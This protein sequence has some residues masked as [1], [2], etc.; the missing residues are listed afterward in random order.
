MKSRE[1]FTDLARLAR[2]IAEARV[3]TIGFEKDGQVHFT[4]AP[5]LTGE[6]VSVASELV[7]RMLQAGTRLEIPDL[8]K[9]EQLTVPE[10][11]EGVPP[12]QFFYGATVREIAGEARWFLAVLDRAPRRLKPEQRGGL[13][14]IGYQIF[15][16]V[17]Q[18][19]SAASLAQ[20]TAELQRA[21]AARREHEAFYQTLVESLPQNI[22][23]KDLDGRFTFANRRFC[24]MLGHPLEE[25][26]GK[27]DSDF[28]PPE[29]AHKYREDDRDVIQR[30][31]PL[32]TTEVNATPDGEKHWVH[33]IKT[34]ILDADGEPVGIQG[35]FWDV[36]K[37]KRAEELLAH[38]R[39]LLRALLDN[40]PDAIYFKDT[41]CRIT[42][43]SKALASKV[44]L[45]DAEGLVGKSDRDLF[46][47]EHAEQS[48]RD[49]LEIIRTGVPKLGY[50]EKETW[51]DGRITWALT[52][53]L[54]LRDR[55]GALIG[56]FGISKDITE[57]KLAQD[58]LERA[59]AN[60]RS[61]VENAI[62]GIFQTTPEGRYLSANPAL[63]RIYGFA[64][65]AELIQQR[66][67]IEHQVYVD[68]D[69]RNEFMRRMQ[70]FGQVDQFESQVYRADGNIFWISENARAVRDAEGTLAYYEGTV[71]DITARKRAEDELNRAYAELKCARD[72]ALES[73]ATKARFLAN[74]SH[75]LR[76]PMNAII[77]FSGLL[78]DTPMTAEQR[79]YAET[80][81]SSARA[82]L[83]LLNDILDFSKIDSGRLVF[84][85]LEFDPRRLIEDTAELMAELAFNKGLQFT[86]WL[87]HALPRQLHGDPGRV[88]QVVTNL[89]ANAIKF[90]EQ[91][92]VQ[93]RVTVE[94][95]N[96]T[97]TRLRFEV[98]DTGVGIPQNAQG[99]IFEAFT[100]AD[101]STTRRFGGSGLG[102]SISRIL[103]Q[104]MAGRIGFQSREGE[105][106]TFWFT[107]ELGSVRSGIGPIVAEDIAQGLRVLIV[108]AHAPTREMV[109]HE[110]EPF[111]C[112]CQFAE[113]AEETLQLLSMAERDSRRIDLALIDL[114]LPDSDGLGLSHEIGQR[115]RRGPIHITL[116]APLGQ[117]FEADA[118]R[119]AGISGQLVKPLRQARL[120]DCLR[121][122][123]SGEGPDWEESRQTGGVAPTRRATSFRIL[124]A[125]D[126]VVNQKV[127]LA[128]LKRLGYSAEIAVNGRRALE[129]LRS[130][131]FE[132][133]LLDC[134]MP[135]W[136]GYETARELRRLEAHGELGSRRPHYIIALTAHAMPGDREKCVA[137]G[138][139]DFLTKPLEIE[140][141]RV[142]LERAALALGYEPSIPSITSNGAAKPSELTPASA[143]LDSKFLNSLRALQSTDAPDEAGEFIDLYLK[144]LPQ[145]LELIRRAIVDRDAAAG[146]AATHALKGSSGNLG[147]KRL[148]GL[149]A[150]LEQALRA[151]DW[152]QA[153]RLL[154]A[155]EVEAGT[156]REELLGFKSN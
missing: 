14:T 109:S 2:R 143:T 94:D 55:Q 75:E 133:I 88:R 29:L 73:A 31:Q 59:E 140:D 25:I 114:Q 138:M 67:D 72:Q 5:E 132:V 105:G 150:S 41:D 12:L 57:L 58:R 6:E 1:D 102:L 11:P 39:D 120:R 113:S 38:E 27:Q 104:R 122:L 35:I 115:F 3:A 148:A 18:Q 99:K 45:A 80:V 78:L 66:T 69:R 84:A 52:S 125:E 90:T 156:L 146:Q 96:E 50:T 36:T 10:P 33:V 16:R 61:I 63:A 64:S 126:N 134:Q 22:F 15:L 116:M 108:S 139:D 100:Q 21:E 47:S 51:P 137:A 91:G 76:T 85:D 147:G 49:E 152:A 95:S 83:T 48:I 89:L 107:I 54:P 111:H 154:G 155:I 43:A 4:V 46:S 60:Y 151:P 106:S 135:E 62:D 17:E 103:V 28:S 7:T 20:T 30:R 117:H 23:R 142:A 32:E 9:E 34:P 19:R 112:D 37:E 40:A 56:T 97:T 118:L 124:L 53:K 93:L 101:E 153:D 128:Q 71:E 81:R 145:R 79:E 44:G 77:G 129:I 98:R 70:Q 65:P 119:A 87:D 26:L 123:A 131:N 82:L 42:R 141:L 149:C 110:L 130:G 127:A 144:D 8:K 121:Q 74:T 13:E 68:P 24:A 136:D 92:E 86:T